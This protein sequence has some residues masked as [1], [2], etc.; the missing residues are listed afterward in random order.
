MPRVPTRP[1]RETTPM[2]RGAARPRRDRTPMPRGTAQPRLN[3]SPTPRV[4]TQPRR[5]R[6]PMPRGTGRRRTRATTTP[7]RGTET[8]QGRNHTPPMGKGLSTSTRLADL[9]ASTSARRRFRQSSRMRLQPRRTRRLPS[10]ATA[11]RTRRR[12]RTFKTS[13]TG[14]NSK[15]RPISWKARS[16]RRSSPPTWTT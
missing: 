8:A 4:S 15:P 9:V 1:R 7:S 11:S 10:K 2:P 13:P 3:G 16:R 5:E 12:K 14:P 6:A